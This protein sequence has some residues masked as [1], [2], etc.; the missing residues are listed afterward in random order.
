ML[1]EDVAVL[2]EEVAGLKND[3]AGLKQDVAEMKG[4]LDEVTQSAHYLVHKTGEHEREIYVLKL[5]QNG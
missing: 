2:K 1:K 3:V 5:R 4:Q